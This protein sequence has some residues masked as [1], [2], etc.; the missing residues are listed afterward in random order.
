MKKILNIFTFLIL[1]VSVLQVSP[2]VKA[3]SSNT[4]EVVFDP[5][6][7]QQ[8]VLGSEKVYSPDGKP[9]CNNRCLSSIIEN[10]QYCKFGTTDQAVAWDQDLTIPLEIASS[11]ALLIYLRAGLYAVLGLVSLGV[12][13]FGIFGWYK[14]AMSEGNAEKVQEVKKI[15]TNAIIGA[16]I[17][18][19]SFVV[20]QMLSNFLGVTESVFDFSFIPKSGYTVNVLDGDTGRVCYEPQKDK[21]NSHSCIDGKWVP[22]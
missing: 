10:N 18:L 12:V 4:D 7:A 2:I 9:I 14:H 13:V 19:M 1:A 20:V 15:Y 11:D 3:S 6:C 21:D 16:I 5:K 17:V 22:N 8:I